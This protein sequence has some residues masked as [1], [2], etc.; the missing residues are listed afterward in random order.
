MLTAQE[1][2][3]N[4]KKYEERTAINKKIIPVMI[5]NERLETFL[6]AKKTMIELKIRA[7]INQDAVKVLPIIILIMMFTIPFAIPKLNQL[8]R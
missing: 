6:D 3:S 4:R 2:W 1:R 5:N 7:V 8:I